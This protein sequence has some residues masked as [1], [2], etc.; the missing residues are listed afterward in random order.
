MISEAIVDAQRKVPNTNYATLS[1]SLT[2]LAPD[3]SDDD[4]PIMALHEAVSDD[5]GESPEAWAARIDNTNKADAKSSR[6]PRLVNTQSGHNRAQRDHTIKT[7]FQKQDA[8]R[9]TT[10]TPPDVAPPPAAP[11]AALQDKPANKK[12]K[13]MNATQIPQPEPLNQTQ[14]AQ[15]HTCP[16]AGFDVGDQSPGLLPNGVRRE[17]HELCRY[18]NFDKTHDWTTCK[19]RKDHRCY[20]CAVLGK[21]GRKCNCG[22]SKRITQYIK[23]HQLFDWLKM[24]E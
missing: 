23:E 11:L 19:R 21:Q 14:I 13:I 5:E 22:A 1:E 6:Q 24:H 18:Y 2:E 9:T 7:M 12:Q 16:L 8:K 10:T 15:Q 4:G 20:L 3:T 17:E